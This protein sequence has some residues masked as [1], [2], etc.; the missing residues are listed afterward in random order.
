ME[1]GGGFVCKE[2]EQRDEDS[3]ASARHKT[4]KR[5]QP[6]VLDVTGSPSMRT[7]VSIQYFC[8]YISVAH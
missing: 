3:Q 7:K 1:A 2:T 4:G 8:A 5:E 6:I